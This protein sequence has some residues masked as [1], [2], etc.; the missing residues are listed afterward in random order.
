MEEA[1]GRLD[2]LK[3]LDD[4]A[5][6]AK[7]RCAAGWFRPVVCTKSAVSKLLTVYDERARRPWPGAE[8]QP[9]VR[10]RVRDLSM[11]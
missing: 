1:Y 3:R 2:S 10:L 7:G 5:M 9:F 11:F 6:C 8:Y 4:G